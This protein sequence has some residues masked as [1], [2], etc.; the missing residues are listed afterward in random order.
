MKEFLIKNDAAG[1]RLDRYLSKLMPL[2]KKTEIQKWIRIKTIKVNGKKQDS[3]YRLIENDI[4]VIYLSDLLLEKYMQEKI[5]LSDT[6]DLDIVYED[7]NILIVNKPEGLLVHPNK[8]EYKNTLSSKVQYYLKHL[9][10]KTFTVSS[11]NRLDKNTSGLVLF[12]KNYDSLK[13]Y[14]E[15]MKEKKIKKKYI[16]IVEGRLLNEKVIE[17]YLLKNEEKNK[18]YFSKYELENSKYIKT[19]VKPIEMKKEFTKVEIELVTGRTH[20]IRVSLKSIGFPIIGDIKY[21]GK[22]V[23]GLNHQLLV[24]NI[25]EF[26]NKKFEIKNEKIEEIWSKLC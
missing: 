23:F 22:K 13:Y 10:T 25:L 20:Q 24:A 11:V 26:E 7:D 5:I 8:E 14:N 15:L 4:V 21:G 19:I 12:C 9:C 17:G 2:A 6:T 3:N 18:V 1:Q 16:S